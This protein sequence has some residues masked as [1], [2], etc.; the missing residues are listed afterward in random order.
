MCFGSE[1]RAESEAVFHQLCAHQS[2][3]DLDKMQTLIQWGWDGAH[4]LTFLKTPR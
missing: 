4:D 1:G 3:W 2:P